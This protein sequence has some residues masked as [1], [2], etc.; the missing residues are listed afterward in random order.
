M[1]NIFKILIVDDDKN[2]SKIMTEAFKME[3]FEAVEWASNGIEA[4]DKYSSQLPDI[5]FMDISMPVMDGYDA[6]RRIKDIDPNAKIIILT[7]NPGDPRVRSILS[8]GLSKRIIQKPVRLN[9]LKSIVCFHAARR[10][11]SDQVPPAYQVPKKE[12]P[13][14]SSV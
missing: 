13:L 10:S 1:S 12:R 14:G 7:G 2:I 5:V 4:I 11:E 6:S 9:Q 8:E 3:G